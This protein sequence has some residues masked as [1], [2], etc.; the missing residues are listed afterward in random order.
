MSTKVS[1]YYC[2][3][4][5]CNIFLKVVPS[6]DLP[7]FTSLWHDFCFGVGRNHAC[8]YQVVAMPMVRERDYVH[9]IMKDSSTYLSSLSFAPI[10][11]QQSMNS[12]ESK[13]KINSARTAKNLEVDSFPAGSLHKNT[14]QQNTVVLLNPE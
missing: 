9:G 6:S 1:Y 14:A 8:S 3:E 13:R 12:A 11:M 2:V 4:S 10:I 5:I 7:V